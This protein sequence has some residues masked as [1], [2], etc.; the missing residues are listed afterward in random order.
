[1]ERYDPQQEGLSRGKSD[2]EG[3]TAGQDLAGYMP[4]SGG[5]FS[6]NIALADGKH[7][8]LNTANG[9][10]I[11]TSSTQKIAFLGATPVTQRSHVSDPSGGST[12]D[13]EARSALASV[14]DILEA[15][16]FMAP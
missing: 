9:S 1:M 3:G 11:G 13:T 10:Q 15:F 12:V 6:G 8:I 4:K 7:I 14:L 16:G 2:S 5:T